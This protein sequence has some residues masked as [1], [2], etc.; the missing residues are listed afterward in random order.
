MEKTAPDQAGLEAPLPPGMA[1]KLAGWSARA[2]QYPIFSKTWFVYRM[3][4]FRAPLLMFGLVVLVLL[5]VIPPPGPGENLMRFYLTFPAL[6]MVVATALM[7]GRGLAVLV[8]RRRWSPRREAAGIVCAL[9]FG[10]LVA[11]AITPFVRTGG[12]PAQGRAPTAQEIEEARETRLINM[13]IWLPVVAWLAGPFDLAAY[14]RQRGLLREA[15]LQAEAERYKHERNEVEMQLAV[16][17]SQVEPHFLFN[18]LSGVRAAMLSDPERGIVMIDHLITYLRSTIPQLR[19]D[20]ASSAVPLG[21]Q[22]DSVQAYLGVVAARMPR[23]GVHVD[24]PPE[25][26]DAAIPP[27][28]LISL[29]ENAVKHGIE[30]KKGPATIRVA[31]SRIEADG[32]PG[33]ALTVTDDGVG[34]GAAAGSGIGLSNIRERLKHLYGG[35]AALSLRAHDAGGVTATIV[36]PLRFLKDGET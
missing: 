22:L 5:A 34:F 31:A 18:T 21:A 8:H 28:M 12:Q 6:W 27:L 15:V 24:C 36:L 4:G 29:A 3:R 2:Q 16:L 13:I 17:A 11:M 19:A 23:L 30:P 10:V 33:L 20:R 25:L 26:R 9:L 32:A 35:A 14:F 1:T 7:L